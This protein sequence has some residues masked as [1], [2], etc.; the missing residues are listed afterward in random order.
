VLDSVV[1]ADHSAAVRNDGRRART[2]VLLALTAT[3]M[4]AGCAGP[5]HS[6]QADSICH[7]A[8][9]QDV[10]S[11]TLSVV[12]AIRHYGVGAGSS[13]GETA[14]ADLPA[15][16]PAA[17]CTIRARPHGFNIYGAAH[18]KAVLYL[19]DLSDGGPPEGPPRGG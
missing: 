7:Q 17:W 19:T 4:A 15:H 11:S 16:E 8:G 14:F 2:G 13:P 5:A 10:K 12:R 9:L 3:G 1:G 6:P 18:G